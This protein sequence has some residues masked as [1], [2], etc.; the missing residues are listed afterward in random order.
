MWSSLLM[1]SEKRLSV[2]VETVARTWHVLG[3]LGLCRWLDGPTLFRFRLVNRA[4]K[5]ECERELS[6][7][8]WNETPPIDE[9]VWITRAN[10]LTVAWALKG[11]CVVCRGKVTRRNW[12]H[13]VVNDLF[14]V[15]AHDDCVRERKLVSTKEYVTQ[16]YCVEMSDIKRAAIDHDVSFPPMLKARRR[17]S[18]LPERA[19]GPR[20][21]SI[22]P[23]LTLDGFIDAVFQAAP[24]LAAKNERIRKYRA[25]AAERAKAREDLA[26]KRSRAVQ[27]R[28]NELRARLGD[29][30]PRLTSKVC[31][32]DPVKTAYDDL[33]A[34]VVTMRKTKRKT[35]DEWKKMIAQAEATID[36][37]DAAL[38]VARVKAQHRVHQ[39]QLSLGSTDWNRL[40]IAIDQSYP[41]KKAWT[42]WND[43]NA[44]D[45]CLRGQCEHGCSHCRRHGT[46]GADF[47]PPDL[48]NVDNWRHLISPETKYITLP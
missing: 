9:K 26:E 29:D 8:E 48:Y 14:P 42:S 11:C 25:A 45:T 22:H 3:D 38:A 27:D 35:V 2:D 20:H 5:D 4:C 37:A 15:H 46:M 7:D 19:W 17:P 6:E 44:L 1:E 21:W 28:I 16:R 18:Y 24:E 41:C 31:A 13:R 36:Q 34:A 12:A 10:W 23:E 39:L 30:A 47:K 33:T 40:M 32:T 43:P